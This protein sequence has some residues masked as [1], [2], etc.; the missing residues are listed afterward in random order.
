MET[1]VHHTLIGLFVLLLTA[2][3][4]IIPLWLSAGF[5]QQQYKTYVVYVN[6]SVD[7]LSVNAP[8]K[9]NG[10]DVGHVKSIS[11]NPAN[12]Q[13]VKILLAIREGTPVTT[14]TTATLTTQG[15][16]GVAY[17]GLKGGKVE[18]AKPLVVKPGATYPQITA[19][20]SIFMRLDT[21]ISQL[22]NNLNEITHKFDQVLTPQNKIL[23]NQSLENFHQVSSN[24]VHNSAKLN[25]SLKS[26]NS[27]V[28]NLNQ[29]ST[30]LPA[31][32]QQLQTTLQNVQNLSQELEENPSV[33][34]RGK[35]PATPGPG[36]QGAQQ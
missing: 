9:Y 32:L 5:D 29:S 15:V 33:L 22:L 18:G 17:V 7:G 28:S 24:L 3:A 12:T 6:E 1:K 8:V 36:E 14:N 19:T 34:L 30:A 2:A 31:S 26:L 23:L 16:T 10:V 25:A 20:P 13:Q 35:S 11:L 21:A 4:I 27:L